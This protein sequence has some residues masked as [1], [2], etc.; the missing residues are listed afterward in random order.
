MVVAHIPPLPMYD[1]PR[2]IPPDAPWRLLQMQMKGKKRRVG[3]WG[4]GRKAVFSQ[5]DGEKSNC[6]C[7][8]SFS[9]EG[10]YFSLSTLLPPILNIPGATASRVL[11]LKKILFY[12]FLILSASL[13]Y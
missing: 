13:L 1:H 6:C 12:A 11:L 4:R 9:L 7:S 5:V 3:G 10:Y 2:P 8:L